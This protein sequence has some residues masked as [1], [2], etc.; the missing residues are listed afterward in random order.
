VFSVRVAN[1]GLMLDP[2]SK[3]S[4]LGDP[5]FEVTGFSAHRRQPERVTGNG[6][7]ERREEFRNGKKKRADG[8]TT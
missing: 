7:K 2:A 5:G 8:E 6:L 1:K 3:A 4:R